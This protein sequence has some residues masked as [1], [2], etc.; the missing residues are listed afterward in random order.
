MG[1]AAAG[2]CLG[3]FFMLTDAQMCIDK[4]QYL[5]INPGEKRP[6]RVNCLFTHTHTHL[7]SE[8]PMDWSQVGTLS[9]S[10]NNNKTT[11]FRHFLPTIALQSHQVQPCGGVCLCIL[12]SLASSLCHGL[13]STLVYGRFGLVLSRTSV[14]FIL[15]HGLNK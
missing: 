4:R 13:H 6:P 8:P 5:F 2:F 7:G 9:K 1:L 3:S 14:S 11:C 15:H 12:E 10:F